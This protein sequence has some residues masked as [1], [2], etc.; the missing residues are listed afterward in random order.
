MDNLRW[1]IIVLVI[2]MHAADTYSP[3]GNW[4]YGDKA[5]TTASEA[6]AF[7]TYQSFV[8]A[9]FMSLLF[10]LS[11]FFAP[12]S[13]AKRGRVEFLKERLFRLGLPLLLYMLVIGPI[14][15]YFVA[16]S[17]R[18]SHPS[19]FALEWWR[20]IADGEVL[21]ESGPLWFCLAL[22]IFSFVYAACARTH[23]QVPQRAAALSLSSLAAFIFSMAALTYLIRIPFPENR[24][25]L[26]MHLGD[27][28][29]YA[30]MFIAGIRLRRSRSLDALKPGSGRLSVAAGIGLG[31]IAWALLVRYGGA[32]A[33]DFSRYSGGAN[34]VSAC[35]CL[36]E[37]FVCVSMSI[38]LT[39]TYRDRINTSSAL[40]RFLSANSFAV[41]VIHPPVLIAITRLMSPLQA[42]S[43][44][45][46][47]L[48][49]LSATIASFLCAFVLRCVP[50]L[51]AIL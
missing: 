50:L 38:G 17:W 20:H 16:G 41:Y 45:K 22:L 42:A 10:S 44:I 18:P 26:N 1:T 31:L 46:F 19:T 23:N 43:S 35:K 3:F 51:R 13:L 47:A 32:L 12:S 8:Q 4:Y 30:L 15:E 6:L 36:W 7:G 27:F 2:G 49:L 37:A 28:P 21:S 48:A 25:V 40:F 9:F 14:T 34:W 33:G 29:E 11:G 39:L 5:Q 24:S